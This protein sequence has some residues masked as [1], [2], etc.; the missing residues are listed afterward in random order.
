MTLPKITDYQFQGKKVLVRADLDLPLTNGQITDDSRLKAL[1]PTLEYLLSQKAKVILIGHLG[2]PGGKV[3]EEFSLEP[4]A[5]RIKELLNY[6][7]VINYQ[8]ENFAA[9]KIGEDLSLLENLR[10]YP[11]E[12]KN[13][14]GFAGKLAELGDFYLNE[15]FAASHREHASI[16]GV[17]G[18]LPHAIG[19]SFA[20]E[21][22]N[23][24]KVLKNPL[25]PI[26]FIVGGAKPET[27]LSLTM[28]FAQK[29][30]W[31]LVGG[32]LPV[33]K[34]F[35]AHCLKFKNILGANL[36]KDVDIDEDSINRFLGAIRMAGTIVWNGPMGKFEEGPKGE[37][38]TK[39]VARA[40]ANSKAFKVVG[41]GDT[42][43]ALNKLGLLSKMDFVSLGGG[44]M[45]EFLAKGTLPGIKA[46]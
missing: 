28:E 40:I 21:V 29:A 14:Q 9:F 11:G 39:V 37:K 45:L 10:F 46:L 22:E 31:V 2:R 33:S 27:K 8:L 26:V 16:V 5:E 30:D 19:F 23:L 18:F 36:K 25:R 4:V 12:E 35:A 1:L 38:G 41:G 44:A 17:P 15:A 34:E 13:D 6:P 24:S 7:S 20:Q 3:V 42:I 43:S 32:L